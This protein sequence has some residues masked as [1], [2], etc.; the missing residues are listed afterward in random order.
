MA[1]KKENEILDLPGVGPATAQK[2][3]ENGY[4]E[5][6]QIATAPIGDIMELCDMTELTA[7]KVIKFAQDKLEMGFKGADIIEESRHN[8]FHIPIGCK[9]FDEMMAG[10]IESGSITEAYGEF[11]SKKTQIAHQLAVNIQLEPLKGIAVYLDS[12]GSFR[13]SRI[14][15]MA[16]AKGLDEEAILKGIKY[17]RA[18]NS[19]HQVIL[20]EKIENMIVEEKLPIRLVI[21]DSL[22]SAF[23]SEYVGR[24]MLADR[25][26][27]INKHMVTLKKL[28]DMYNIAVYVTNQVSVDPA[29]M[30]GDPTKAI[31]G[32]IV[33]HAS[34]HRIYLRKGKKGSGVA[35]LIDSPN[36]PDSESIFNVVEGGIVD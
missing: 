3:M 29:Q 6:K 12:E 36:L 34:T 13:P 9:A 31:G 28:A 18:F 4:T 5:L 27:K 16:K 30:F 22:T 24:G 23:R 17:A 8:I 19:D 2:L 11:G 1:K 20:A 33:G 21:V 25:Q 10:G 15:Q 7:K 26:Q 32:H 35:K 14:R